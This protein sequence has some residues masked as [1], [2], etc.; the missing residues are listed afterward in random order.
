VNEVAA[1]SILSDY[2]LSSEQEGA[3]R[4]DDSAI[5]VIGSAGGGK[6]EVVAR[7]VERLLRESPGEAFRILALS[8]TLKAADELGQRLDERLGDLSRRVDTNTVHAFAHS[9]LRQ[10]GTRL[11]LPVEP[12]VLVRNED[13]AELLSRWLAAEGRPISEDL[14][15]VFQ[16]LD[17][18]RARQQF[19][20]LQDEW[21][22]A[23]RSEGALDYGSMLI[24]ATELLELQSVHRQLARLYAHIIV[25]EAQ[26]LTAAQYT[27][28]T[29]LIGSPAA[30]EHLPIMFV[31]DDKQSIVGFAGA[32]PELISRYTREYSP[33]LFELRQNFRSA[34]SIVAL[35]DSVGQRLGQLDS[36]DANTTIEYAA[37]GLVE[38]NEAA[39]EQSEALLVSTWILNLLEHGLPQ[40]ALAP[41]EN[42]LVRPDHIAV[43]ARSAAALRATQSALEAAGQK[44]AIS[45]SPEDWLATLTAKAALEIVALRSA[46]S[47]RST[48][49]Q[50][51]R[52]LDTDETKVGTPE[53]LACVLDS[54]ANPEV[55]L[56]THLCALNDPADFMDALAHLEMPSDLDD[57]W[58]AA[59]DG[60]CRQLVDSW[61]SFIQ[62]ADL[63]EQT[64]GNFRL[65]VS[66]QQ[67]GDDLDPGVRLLTIHKAQG[68][69]YR[70]V[71]LVGL[72]DGQLPDFRAT[73]P[74]NQ[75]SELRTFYVAVTRPSRLLL[76]T[77]ALWRRTR[78][79]ARR[80]EPSPFLSFIGGGR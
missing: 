71:A 60:D 22:A 66:R 11:G 25:D 38:V 43:L 17:L 54:H 41:G 79:G 9:L 53:E 18:A 3:V 65:H 36:E 16:H 70:A 73:S 12:E 67:R 55:R 28:L 30:A 47:H 39:D 13:R 15:V 21:Q 76:I 19:A 68:R 20:P 2:R 77:R 63:V 72:N 37:P 52:L 74:E 75:L 14:L 7:R 5:L 45:S 58:L 27:L 64:W 46:S 33:K 42:C 44:P 50:L 24:C 49:W 32:D 6:T 69:E 4:S 57:Q 78:Y 80:T 23:L 31:G 51:A 29:T 26:N 1:M 35:G 8:Y 10:Y 56:L 40:Q 48:H 59:W 61:L 34:A 62:H